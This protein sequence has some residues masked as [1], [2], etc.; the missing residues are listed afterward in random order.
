VKGRRAEGDVTDDGLRVGRD[1][2]DVRVAV[3]AQGV[4]EPGFVDAADASVCTASI[5]PTSPV[6]SRRT[7]ITRSS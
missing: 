4:D 1:E 7:S 6:P 2:P 5:A 3:N